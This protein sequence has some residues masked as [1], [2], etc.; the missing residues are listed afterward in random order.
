M[1]TGVVNDLEVL[2]YGPDST[3][4]WDGSGCL[5]HVEVVGVGA[6]HDRPAVPV[7]L[8]DQGLPP[9]KPTAQTLV[10]ERTATP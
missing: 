5:Q 4:G 7:P 1:N 10:G 3:G 6:G 2:S 8:L 9:D